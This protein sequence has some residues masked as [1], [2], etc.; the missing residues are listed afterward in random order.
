MNMQ[1]RQHL[2]ILRNLAMKFT[3]DSDE[4]NDLVQETVLRALKYVDQ[5]SENPKVISWLFVIMRNVYIN[6]YR[7]RKQQYL[8]ENYQLHHYKDYA[9]PFKEHN[10]EQKILIREV[11]ETLSEMPNAYGDIFNKYINGYKYKEISEIYNVPEGTIKSRIHQIKRK[12]QKKF[13]S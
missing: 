13:V 1:L 10:L 12:L 8:Y 3:K 6:L 9:D 4:I 5:L 2:A 11:Q 7:T